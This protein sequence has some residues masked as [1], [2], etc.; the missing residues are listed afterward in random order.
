[1]NRRVD[2]VLDSV[3]L[4]R[5]PRGLAKSES[6]VYAHAVGVLQHETTVSAN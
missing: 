5:C 1:M 4:G 2:V 3:F 6:F